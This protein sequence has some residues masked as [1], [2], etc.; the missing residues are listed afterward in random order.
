MNE[1]FISVNEFRKRLEQH[2][3]HAKNPMV[4]SHLGMPMGYFIPA[5]IWHDRA[6]IEV[7]NELVQAVLEMSGYDEQDVK[8]AIESFTSANADVIRERMQRHLNR[9]DPASA[10]GKYGNVAK[11]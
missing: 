3:L 4:I 6:T 9:V 10:R 11:R 5:R 1:A 7:F 8:E 2:M